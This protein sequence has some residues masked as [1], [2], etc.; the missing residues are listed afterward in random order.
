ML[1]KELENLDLTEVEFDPFVG[2]EIVCVAPSTEAQQEI[3]IACLFGGDDANRAFNE[4]V[5]LR[6]RGRF[7][8]AAMEK[9]LQALVK[10]HEA[11]HSAFGA[12]GREICV[13]KDLAADFA[14]Q[15]IT[16]KSEEEQEQ[17][18]AK[19]TQQ[20]ALLPFN[21]LYGPLFRSSLI[22]LSDQEHHL[23]LTAH[24]VVCD[25]WSLGIMMQDLGKLYSAQVQDV[26]PDLTKAINFSQFASEQ[27]SYAK[28]EDYRAVEKFWLD[29]YKNNAPVVTLPTDFPRPSLRTFKSNR[30]D[31]PLKPGLVPAIKK[32]GLKAGCSFVTTLMAGFDVLLHRLTGQNEIVVGLPTAGQSA[33]GNHWLVGHCVNLLPLRSTLTPEVSFVDFLKQRKA[34][35]FD[36]YEHQ[37]LTFGSL[38]KKLS[39]PRDASRIPLVPVVFNV[40]MGLA[41]GVEFHEL[42]Y[43]LISNPREYESF[44]LFLNASG[45]EK[46]VVLECSY[47]SALFKPAT[48]KQMMAEFEQ[49]LE[50]VVENPSIKVTAIQL[51][52]ATNPAEAYA[53]LNSTTQP[54]PVSK[55]LHQ[56]LSEQAKRTP[57]ATAIKFGNFV[58]SYQ[59]LET[60]ANQLANYLAASQVRPGDVVG[61]LLERS[62]DLVIALLAIMKCGAAYVPL[63]PIYPEERIS[64]MLA[65]SGARFLFASEKLGAAFSTSATKLCAEDAF[66]ASRGYSTTAPRREQES[67]SLLYV[68]YTSGSTGKPKGVQ[69][70]HRNVVNFLCSMQQEPGITAADKLLAVTTI[71]FD[72]AGLEL[73]LPLISGAAIV[74]ADA[75]TTKDGKL[76]RELIEQERVTILQAT[77]ATWRM[78]LE[79]GWTKKLPLKALCGGEAL[80]AELAARLVAKCDSVWNMYGPTETTIWSSV[81][82]V[83]DVE[84]NITVGK[85]IANTQFYILDDQLR[86]VEPG[87][88]GEIIIAGDGVGQGYLNRPELTAEK[89]VTNPF[90][91][92]NGATMYRTGDLGK[93]LPSGEVQCLGRVDQQVKVR[94]YRI[95]PGE[96]EQVLV[97]FD[98][99]KEA[100]VLAR[101]E[102]LVAFVVPAAALSLAAAQQRIAEWK[103][104]LARLLPAYMVPSEV[105]VLSA[106]P[107]TLN[108]KVDRKALLEQPKEAAKQ[109]HDHYVAPRTESE[110][111]VAS[112]WCDC[113]KLEQVSIYDNFFELG[114]HSLIAVQ[115][116]ARLEQETGKRLPLSTL[117][118]YSTVQKLAS[119]VQAND[120]VITWDSL[121]DSL[122]PIQPCGSKTPLY[123]VHGAGMNV[124]L[125]N[126]LAKNMDPDQP[127]YGLQ[128]KGL[129]GIDEPLGTIEEIAAHYIAA[130][131]ATNPDG[132]YA[133]AG[134]SFGGVIAYEMASQLVKAGKVVKS[135]IMFDTYAYQAYSAKPGKAKRRAKVKYLL[136]KTAYTFVLLAKRP[137]RTLFYKAD[138]VKRMFL[139]P[140]LTLKHGKERQY[141]ILNGH[142]YQLAVKNNLA[143]QAYE[144]TPQPLAIDLFRVDTPTYYMH[145]TEFLGWKNLALKGVNIHQVQGEHGCIFDAPN[146]QKIAETLQIILNKS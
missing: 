6:L 60:S 88:V 32:M 7:D 83:A 13:F 27:L 59:E 140:Y 69:I 93:L 67:S 44:E 1:V 145:D 103:K 40:D 107:M 31:Y 136:Q 82:H 121:W 135:L 10:R 53:E 100:V 19:Y 47:N 141:E 46:S 118:E 102:R 94:G 81:K 98:D 58:L 66:Q 16:N 17:F 80:P 99:L 30:L 104:A 36:A 126:T 73:F 72:I 79:A 56:L 18:I 55:T 120:E 109:L 138:T 89:F 14:Y 33:T 3:W 128:A 45:S 38:L 76:L 143:E 84:E 8:K 105:V 42:E 134:Y 146:D 77:P 4:S 116:M 112:I 34:F 28:S 133:L 68:L 29:Q 115:V 11:L 129:N 54:Y 132:P 110:K 39:I 90:A 130:I 106:L 23:T 114:G 131:S 87:V 139:R 63:D 21:L 124:L 71:S 95:E 144:L 127:V 57:H 75:M 113:L 125:F 50:Q 78:L 117:F 64:F 43:E 2:P 97:S 101:D 74:L 65:D 108:G 96:I 70:T 123:I 15:D 37:Q 85:P 35:L 122:V 91:E 51:G 22:K 49:L 25:G 12:N 62:P 26:Y 5:S 86:L 9:A 61:L 52:S 48:I 137:G 24:H 20:N 92:E 142:P 119:V 41:D 111:L